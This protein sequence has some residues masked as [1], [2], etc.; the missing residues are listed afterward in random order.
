MR[1]GEI[2]SKLIMWKFKV[3]QSWMDIQFLPNILNNE[4]FNVRVTKRADWF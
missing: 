1:N 4:E 3:L 2:A